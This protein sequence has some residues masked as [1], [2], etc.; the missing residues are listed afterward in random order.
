MKCHIAAIILSLS[1]QCTG[2]T[3]YPHDSKK[4]AHKIKNSFPLNTSVQ[5]QSIANVGLDQPMSRRILT[6]GICSSLFTV[7]LFSAGILSNPSTSAA[8]SNAG[9]TIWKTGKA[10]EVP[11]QKPKDKSDTKGTRKDPNFLRSIADCKGKCENSPGPDGLARSSAECLSACQDIC[12]TTYE[13]CT[14]AII[15]R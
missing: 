15:A 3:T 14:F 4:S 5:N 1:Q 2:F 9:A 10:P 12:C 7:G 13:Q 8:D 11:G 6:R